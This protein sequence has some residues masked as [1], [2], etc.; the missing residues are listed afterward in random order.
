MPTRSILSVVFLAAGLALA[1]LGFWQTVQQLSVISDQS[2]TL[3]ARSHRLLS[4]GIQRFYDLSAKIEALRNGQKSH[5]L[6]ETKVSFDA[7]FTLLNEIKA[8]ISSSASTAINT[9]IEEI[10][11]VL[12]EIERLLVAPQ[13]DYYTLAQA[14]AR[15]N[16]ASGFLIEEQT[17]ISAN[18]M[19]GVDRL[20]E[21]SHLILLQFGMVGLGGL[22][23]V[24]ALWLRRGRKFGQ[25]GRALDDTVAPDFYRSLFAGMP[26][27]CVVETKDRM[28]LANPAAAQ[29]LG[30]LTPDRLLEET[31]IA[32]MVDAN[33]Q[34]AFADLVKRISGRL[35]EEG[36]IS[37]F[38]WRSDKKRLRVD[39]ILRGLVWDDKPAVQIAVFDRTADFEVDQFMA[40]SHDAAIAANLVKSR[41]LSSVSHEIR[42]PM[43]AI[44]GLSDIALDLETSTK[45]REYLRK[46]REAGRQLLSITNDILDFSQVSNDKI[47]L[48]ITN[49]DLDRVIDHSIDMISNRAEDKGLELLVRFGKDVPN[50]LKGD[51]LR[52]G[53]IL[54]HLLSNAVKFTEKGEVE[55]K[56]ELVKRDEPIAQLKFSVRDTGVGMSDDDQEK[57]FSAFFQAD[58]E[59]DKK[60]QGTGMGL[61][62]SQRLAQLMGGQ[63]TAKSKLGQGSIFSFTCPFEEIITQQAVSPDSL[64]YLRVLVVD[65]NPNAREIVLEQISGLSFRPVAVESGYEALREMEASVS[66]GEPFDLVLMDWRMPVIDG[67]M[68]SRLIRANADLAHI[69]IFIMSSATA[70]ETLRTE[71]RALAI[72]GFIS[73]PI[74]GA[75]FLENIANAF[76]RRREMR[77]PRSRRRKL[78]D[79]VAARFKDLKALVVE[80][81][82]INRQVM[83]EFLESVGIQVELA[84]NGQVAVERMESLGEQNDIGVILMDIDMPVMDGFLA[85]A[86][87]K[88]NPTFAK[89]PIVALTGYTSVEERNRCLAAGMVAHLAKP[90][91]PDRL[92]Q[93]LAELLFEGQQTA[94]VPMARVAAMVAPQSPERQLM[95]LGFDIEGQARWLVENW[96]LL[97][98]LLGD[99]IKDYRDVV[100]QMRALLSSQD[101][102]EAAR[103]A[104]SLKG[105]AGNLG[106]QPIEIAA[107]DIENLLRRESDVGVNEAVARL[108]VVARETFDGLSVWLAR[109]SNHEGADSGPTIVVEVPEEWRDL[110]QQVDLML[111]KRRYAAKTAALLLA[112]RLNTLPE[113]VV[114]ADQMSKS[115]NR[116]DYIS[117]RKA[118]A[119]ISIQLGMA[120]HGGKL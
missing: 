67:L 39:L 93:C 81:N 36:N 32:Q 111:S 119:E 58:G 74:N 76:R 43:N 98:S 11:L 116:L 86:R 13:L 80:D 48:D 94:M 120:D 65:D 118:L 99:F 17:R 89:I 110:V 19:S 9:S 79:H 33:D 24:G 100:N 51:A 46:I 101:Y 22:C 70:D 4:A 106:A 62:L 115:V 23:L 49:F 90:I 91:D 40:N 10:D 21:Q 8:T 87:I 96:E 52:L 16:L 12:K 6:D 29:L 64:K 72:D 105:V 82:E 20:Q 50:R 56:I 14:S 26:Q 54:G 28:I 47:E 3:D 84:A 7:S 27:A 113:L 2:A 1:A 71:S 83:Q 25:S 45:T 31:K 68:T 92:F 77:E 114:L 57:L 15:L 88:S 103:L 61:A 85:T 37:V 66:R 38:L 69:P 78:P 42:T 18:L 53:Q 35:G 44:I 75:N 95:D 73:K 117:A 34:S 108:E 59:L 104:H 55:L 107:R 5:Q 112:E 30:Y 60:F 109:W 41:F 97:V 102:R 63:I